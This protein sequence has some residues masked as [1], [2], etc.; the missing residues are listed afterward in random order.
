MRH[1]IAGAFVA[2]AASVALADTLTLNDGSKLEGRFVEQRADEIVFDQAVG[3]RTLRLTLRQ[4]DVKSIELKKLEPR[5]E[6]AALPT[7]PTPTSPA[8]YPELKGYDKHV[9]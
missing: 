3:A 6:T 9:I 7:L 8:D 2:L 1:L 5:K 4:S